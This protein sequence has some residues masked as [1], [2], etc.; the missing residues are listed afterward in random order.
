[1]IVLVSSRSGGGEFGADEFGVDELGADEFGAGCGTGFRLEI[2]G[3]SRFLGAA[4]AVPLRM[5]RTKGRRRWVDGALCRSAV[6]WSRSVRSR[7]SDRLQDT[8]L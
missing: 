7:V 6:G 4:M 3:V 2:P 8:S 1:M 5:R